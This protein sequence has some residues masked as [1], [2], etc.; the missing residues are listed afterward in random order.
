MSR[1]NNLAV[2]HDQ[3]LLSNYKLSD[4]TELVVVTTADRSRTLMLL[5]T[6]YQRR[7]VSTLE[8]YAVWASTYDQEK[9][10]LI[11]VEEPYVD[12]LLDTLAVTTALDVGTGTGRHALKLARRGIAVTAIDQSPEMLAVA[13]QAAS[14]EGLTIDFQLA[15]IDE[16][17][18]F[19]AGQFDLLICALVL[20]HVPNLSP[21][22]QEFYRVLRPSGFVLVT[23]FHPD[24]NERG[25][26][27]AFVRL[28]ATYTLPNAPH[29]RTDYVETLERTGF[30]LLR[31]VDAL[32]DEIPDDYPAKALLQKQMGKTFCLV[33]LAQK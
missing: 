31:V 5:E 32:V 7:E 22:I 6:E 20:C 3:T 9:N 2:Q 4:G 16:Q 12:A 18:P 10:T 19:E 15:S 27:T 30:T 17:L 29:T 11:G 24:A 26:R 25:W 13:R 8:G 1:Y 28:G 14:S 33:I 23:D 21:A